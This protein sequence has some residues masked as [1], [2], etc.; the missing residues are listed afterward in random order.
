MSN[1]KKYS[2]LADTS[3]NVIKN[4]K[5][6]N[7]ESTDHKKSLV[8]NNKVVIVDIYADWCQPCKSIAPR[9]SNMANEYEKY[10][11]V[12]LK[13]DVEKKISQNIRGV[14]SFQFFYNGQ[15]VDTS[16]GADM[17]EVKTKVDNLVGILTQDMQNQGINQ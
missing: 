13:E 7:I 3:S 12:F 10:G 15:M 2:D 8:F 9:F 1:Y 17:T 5:V 14:P 16:T 11:F 6:I 4:D